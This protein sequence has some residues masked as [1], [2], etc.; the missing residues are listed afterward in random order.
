MFSVLTL[1]F[2]APVQRYSG[3][4]L[5]VTATASFE[6]RVA[7]VELRGVPLGGRL[8]GAAWLDEEGEL[9]V[10]ASFSRALGRRLVRLHTVREHEDRVEV[11]LSIPVFGTRTVALHRER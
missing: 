9:T 1:V 4:L 2:C 7:N 10:D 8:S 5:G 11:T 3:N 6:N